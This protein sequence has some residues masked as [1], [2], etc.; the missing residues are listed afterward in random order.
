MKRKKIEKLSDII[1]EKLKDELYN[2][3]TKAAEDYITKADSETFNKFEKIINNLLNYDINVNIDSGYLG[4]YT[5]DIKSIKNKIKNTK[6]GKVNDD[7]R[8]EISIN[9][10][11]FTINIGYNQRSSFLYEGVYDHFYEKFVK[12]LDNKNNKNFSETYNV[13]M[14][15]SGLLRDENLENLLKEEV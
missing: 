13:L 3:T 4:I 7:D 12:Y 5:D 8:L 2:G 1:S 15:E 6:F 14:K 9:K 11:R 10:N